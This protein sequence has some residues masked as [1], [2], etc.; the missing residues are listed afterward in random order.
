MDFESAYKAVAKSIQDAY[1]TV[2][3]QI[4]MVA[5]S[6]MQEAFKKVKTMEDI[7]TLHN[8]SSDSPKLDG[9]YIVRQ[10][11]EK[12]MGKIDTVDVS[13]SAKLRISSLNEMAQ[14]LV[15]PDLSTTLAVNAFIDFCN[16]NYLRM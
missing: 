7:L 8:E 10:K 14:S 2:S 9:E 13:Y 15:K 1:D 5:V 11:F 12:Y 3:H 16:E 6:G 4:E